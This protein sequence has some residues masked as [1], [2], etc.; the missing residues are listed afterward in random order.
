MRRAREVISRAISPKWFGVYAPCTFPRSGARG[1]R[2]CYPFLL[3]SVPLRRV[4]EMIETCDLVRVESRRSTWRFRG[5]AASCR[6]E[7]ARRALH[8]RWS[9]YIVFFSVFFLALT[10]ST[11]TAI[12]ANCLSA[13]KSNFLLFLRKRRKNA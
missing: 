4:L 10:S 6:C 5:A 2:Q 9:R 1:R 13:K 8:A 7:R 3:V 11:A 12:P